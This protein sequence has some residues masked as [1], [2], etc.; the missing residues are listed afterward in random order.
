MSTTPASIDEVLDSLDR[1][2]ER[3]QARGSRL[4]Y[5]AAIYRTV[6]ATVK[7]GIAN[8]FFDDGERMERLDV[9]FA[10]RYLDALDAYEHGLSPTRSWRVACEGATRWRPIVL[11]HLLAGINAHINLDLG[12]AAAEIAPAEQLPGLRR[13][14]D[15]INQILSDVQRQ[16]SDRIGEISPGMGLIDALAGRSDEMVVR[17]SIEVARTKAWRFAT[18]LAPVPAEQRAGPIGARDAQIARVGRLILE[19]GPLLSGALL[20]VRLRERRDVAAN[21]DVLA[22]LAEPDLVE[23]DAQVRRPSADGLDP[24]DR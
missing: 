7:D 23:L 2:L 9:A 12:I 16:V 20:A 1:V 5:F 24:S 4:G 17:F 22:A 10:N 11:Q 21:I 8:D 18:E 6:T 19:P 3:T 14:F 15:R 13:D